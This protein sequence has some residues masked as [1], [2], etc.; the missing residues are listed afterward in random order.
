MDPLSQLHDIQLPAPIAWWPLA[1]GWYL[2]I[3]LLVALIVLSARFFWQR[4][5][6]ALKR[7]ALRLLMEADYASASTLL[8]RLALY[9]YPDENIAGLRGESWL[10]F[11]D[12]TGQTK[13]FTQGV[14][15][16][17]L[18]APYQQ[19]FTSIDTALLDLLTDWINRQEIT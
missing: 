12:K 16:A 11:L 7:E 9:Q 10:A 4:K 6:R 2:L 8:R 5:K 14:G 17:L 19:M 18:T 3:A 1:P 13:A 15:R